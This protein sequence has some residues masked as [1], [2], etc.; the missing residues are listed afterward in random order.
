M[1]TDEEKI[2][3]QLDNNH[4]NESGSDIAES[5]EREKAGLKARRKVDTTVLPLLFLGLLV[6]QL[7]R[8]NLASALTDG[9]AKTIGVN[10]NTIN[11]GNQL[12]FLG[13]VVLEIPSNLIL[14]R[15]GPRK[16][17]SAQVFIFGLVASLQVFVK[18]RAGFLASRMFLGLCEAGYIPG[19]I[20]TLST[21]YTK[22]ESAKRVAV[23]FFGMFGGNA[24]SPLLA[25]GILK[26]RG[27]QGLAGWQWLFLIEG[28]FTMVV[29]LVLL[30]LL[31]GSPDQ[32]RPLLSPGLIHFSPADQEGLKKR[33]E[34][35][36]PGRR[37]GA[38]GMEIP[39]KLVWQTVKHYRRWPHFVS[40]FA[41][42]S[43]WSSLTTYT[44]SIIMALGFDRIEANALA[45]VGGFIA[46]GVVFF[47]GWLSDY[48]NKRGISVVIAHICYLIV[49]IICREVHPNVGK[50]SRWGLWTSVN[51]FAIG[52][53]PIHNSWVQLN[54]QDPRERSISIAMWVMSA[55][56]GLMVGTQ[57][58]RA[59][60]L[61]FYNKGLRT[62][63]IMVSIGMFFAIVQEAVYL[64]YNK[65]AL[66][67]H[68]EEGGE[69]PWLYQP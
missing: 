67:K 3:V 16:W 64:R 62:Q 27:R 11:L 38:Q 5:I 52:Y 63:I 30:F 2:A 13:I 9:F 58:Y 29:S 51:A 42:F 50:W 33:I 59:D 54:C 39:L 20:Y 15:I 49:L 44:P 34:D 55:I 35:D 31:P 46:L 21:W 45:C 19:A 56:S 8:M 6:F 61:P 66:K 24:I 65:K 14:Q 37:H 4:N 43:T 12:M 69:R 18:D 40:T 68:Q 10:Q 53:H 47:F 32:P 41:V 7:D 48:T 28:V 25:S 26:L 60:D 36:D 22:R 23:F 1:S 57:Y 17:I